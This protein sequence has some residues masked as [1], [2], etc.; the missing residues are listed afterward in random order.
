MGTSRPLSGKGACASSSKRP[1]TWRYVVW[2]MRSVPGG[3]VCS[4]RAAMLTLKPR[5]LCSPSTPPPNNTLPVCSPTRTL[6]PATPWLCSRA[7]AW[8]RAWARI[9]SPA[10]TARSAS[11]SNAFGA[12]NT[13]SR[14]SPAYCK[15][16]PRWAS[17]WAVKRASAP[18]ITAFRSSASRCWLMAVEPTMSANST[19]ASLS[20]GSASPTSG[21]S[22][23]T[24]TGANEGRSPLAAICAC[25]PAT[26]ASTTASPSTAR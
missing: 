25:K 18:S 8:L 10:S 5:M 26:A 20:W 22:M 23:G 24:G 21:L 3:A 15:T 12:P 13:A 9:A 16:R 7:W 6:K 1:R 11:S 4:M 17:T 2:L 14:L 19:V